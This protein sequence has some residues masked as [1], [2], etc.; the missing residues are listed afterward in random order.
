MT[1]LCAAAPALEGL[2]PYD[3]NYKPAE[4][5]ISV[6]E[7][8][9]NVPAPVRR[10]I[11]ERVEALA[12]NRYPNPL[13][14]PLRDALAE[15]YGLGRENVLVANGGDELLLNLFLAWGGAGRSCVNF[16]PTFSV[17]EAN[18]RLTCTKVVNV[19]RREDFTVDVEAACQAAASAEIV[20]ICAPNNP[21]GT[22]ISRPD[23]VRILKSTNA[24]VL[25]DEAYA[26]FASGDYVD[27]IASFENLAILRTFSKAFACAG[28]RLGYLLAGQRVI[29]EFKKVRQPYSVD[30]IS[31]IV[32]EEV[33]ASLDLY[34]G[35]VSMLKHNREKLAAALRELGLEVWPSQANFLL[36]RVPDAHR[37]W[38][39][40]YENHS[41]LVRDFSANPLTP[42]CL[43]I[44]VSTET[45]NAALL[46]ALTTTLKEA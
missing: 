35:A 18:A 25:L 31:Q 17:Y 19:P 15:L 6:N 40:L 21:T 4:V 36:V 43:R 33:L 39:H 26:E 5:P 7:S 22:G 9:L 24:L 3:P 29:N 44:T 12:M 16:P 28:V 41:V 37:V 46:A 42:D 34:A 14:N 20:I 1:K 38:E 27:L 32:G 8:P 2:V 23:L 10:R 11:A 30:A 45:E 13:A